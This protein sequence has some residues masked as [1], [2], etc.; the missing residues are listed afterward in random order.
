[1]TD[2]IQS[3]GQQCSLSLPLSLHQSSFSQNHWERDGQWGKGAQKD[4]GRDE[5]EMKAAEVINMAWRK[6]RSFR[7]Q[8][9]GSGRED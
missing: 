8:E 9:G 2:V 1:M 3:D 7:K 4:L 6:C 5:M